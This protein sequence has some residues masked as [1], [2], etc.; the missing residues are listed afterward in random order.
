MSILE[1]WLPRTTVRPRPSRSTPLGTCASTNSSRSTNVRTARST[2]PT[3]PPARMSA[4]T[5]AMRRSPRAGPC[6]PRPQT[7][8]YAC[9]FGRL[10]STSSV[11]AWTPCAA[12]SAAVDAL[13]LG[14][15]SAKHARQPYRTSPLEPGR[16]RR[17]V[18]R[19]HRPPPRPA[20]RGR[21]LLGRVAGGTAAAPW[22][23]PGDPC[24]RCAEAAVR[25][26]CLPRRRRSERAAAEESP[27]A[28]HQIA[29][30][31]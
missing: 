23:R 15:S 1:V 12:S 4:E 24:G 5:S 26:V 11:G 20:V 7:P 16:V 13:G 18:W 28:S 10:A 19:T 6:R 17:R 14:P 9:Q 21:P 30:V 3:C 29:D 27:P 2:P 31:A 22:A 8:R 25:K